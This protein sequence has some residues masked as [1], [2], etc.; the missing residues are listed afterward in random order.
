[1]NRQFTLDR[2]SQVSIL[3]GFAVSHVLDVRCKEAPWDLGSSYRMLT[4]L[5]TCGVEVVPVWALGR[6]A[7]V[8]AVATARLW[9]SHANAVALGDSLTAG[10]IVT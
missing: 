10:D 7:V 3:V 1:M 4:D 2:L 9:T 5:Y 8:P 6:M